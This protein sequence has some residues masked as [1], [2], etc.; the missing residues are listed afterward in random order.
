[1]E[2]P[3]R[4]EEGGRINIF[5]HTYLFYMAKVA[6]LIFFFDKII[7]APPYLIYQS[8]LD[9]CRNMIYIFVSLS[10][11]D[12]FI[13]VLNKKMILHSNKLM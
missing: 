2:F 12:N 5:P 6:T 7:N 13:N 4:E 10:I 8:F 11:E 9:K 3:K 1:M